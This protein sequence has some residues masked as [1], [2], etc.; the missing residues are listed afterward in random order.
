MLKV[1]KKNI[2]EINWLDCA[3]GD[4]KHLDDEID[5]YALYWCGEFDYG[6]A[7]YA[8]RKDGTVWLW[9]HFGNF[10]DEA[11]PGCGYPTIGIIVMLMILAK[12]KTM[13]KNTNI[14][15]HKT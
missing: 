10:P 5:N 3:F 7:Y 13:H 11:I 12:L 2:K 15:E 14:E 6:R 1:K 9:K 4:R 8:I